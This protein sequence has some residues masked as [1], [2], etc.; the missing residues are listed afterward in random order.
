MRTH[1]SS[2]NRR[3]FLQAMGIGGLFFTTRGAFA[4]AL[5]LTPSQTIGPY[6]PDRMPLDLDNDLLVINDNIT[7]AVG[8]ISW[9]SGRVLDRTGQAVRGALVEIW[10]AD[11]NGAYIHSRSPSANRDANFQ[12]YG[13]FL[14]GS[15]GEYLFRTVRP[16]LYPGR[17]RH[18]HMAVSPPGQSRLIT[19]LYVLGDSRNAAD[20]VLNGIRDEAQRASVV[21]PWSAVPGSAVGELSANFDIVLGFTPVENPDASKPTMVSMV[22][23]AT[24]NPGAAAGS[25]MTVFGTGL[26]SVNVLIDNKPM[27]VL[28]STPAQVTVQTPPDAVGIV[29][30][31]VTNDAGA[32]AA[33][34][35][36]IQPLM[37][38][39]FLTEQDYVLQPDPPLQPG[40][41]VVLLGTGFGPTV[42]EDAGQLLNRVKVQ[43]DTTIADA[44]F[45]GLSDTGV[46]QFKLIVPDLPDGD[47]SVSAEV[48]GVRTAKIG[49]LRIQRS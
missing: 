15:T 21:V 16:G 8:D 49:R 22:N 19:Q 30:V 7:P 28:K 5:T 38:G 46:Q 18:V 2:T 27:P 44:T 26:E 41:E 17:T 35:V 31:T 42:P 1:N 32:S 29:D 33:G 24:L 25:W 12:G 45:A 4:E 34:T 14:T 9:I 11:N 6:Y 13:K 40:A 3:Q 43:I 20:G 23:A 48:A 10:Q 39:F 37:P 36:N 47:H